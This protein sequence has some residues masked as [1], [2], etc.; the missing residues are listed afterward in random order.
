MRGVITTCD[1]LMQV[2]GCRRVFDA[3]LRIKSLA[4]TS[5]KADDA[6]ST[7]RFGGLPNVAA[8]RAAAD[9]LESGD[10]Q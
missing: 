7:F 5:D 6:R 3:G 8:S 10:G 1:L 9:G 2:L 4:N